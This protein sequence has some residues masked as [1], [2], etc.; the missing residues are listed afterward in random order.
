[1]SGAMTRKSCARPGP[2]ADHSADVVGKP[3]S[4]TT[5]GPSPR[6]TYAIR[7]P[8]SPTVNPSVAAQSVTGGPGDRVDD[9][10]HLAHLPHVVHPNDLDPVGG[11]PRHRA[12]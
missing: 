4:S 5:A 6:S 8:P 2:I 11:E 3:C 10:H 12:G 1:M 9:L 7:P